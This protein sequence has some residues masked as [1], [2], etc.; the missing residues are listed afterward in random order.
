ME[1]VRQPPFLA[2][3]HGDRVDDAFERT[4]SGWKNRMTQTEEMP[5]C[6]IQ[7]PQKKFL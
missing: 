6:R 5:Q 3:D 4:L 2:V 7:R 1:V